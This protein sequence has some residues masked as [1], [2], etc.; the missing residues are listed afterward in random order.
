MRV[1]GEGR[2]IEKEGSEAWRRNASGGA[3]DG[4]GVREVAEEA[5]VGDG[6]DIFDAERSFRTGRVTHA[7][8]EE[9][10]AVRE[11]ADD[12]DL[13]L[14]HNLRAR[15]LP[16]PPQHP[17]PRRPL[18]PLDQLALQRDEQLQEPVLLASLLVSC[19]V[20]VPCQRNRHR[21]EV[22]GHEGAPCPS[23]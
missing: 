18:L 15:H 1:E 21:Q 23:S 2:K 12:V 11:G 20:C 10:E 7:G 13:L 14:G 17:V 22:A 5:V 4:L 9:R 19:V 8:E 3:V 6:R 16:W